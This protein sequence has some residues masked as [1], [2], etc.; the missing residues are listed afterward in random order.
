MRTEL[1][2]FLNKCD[3]LDRK[4]RGGVVFGEYVKAY[5]GENGVAGVCKCMCVAMTILFFF[6][7]CFFVKQR[8][9]FLKM[10]VSGWLTDYYV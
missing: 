7:S 3:L 5:K 1:V 10:F 6:F 8:I 4:L 9:V 2:L